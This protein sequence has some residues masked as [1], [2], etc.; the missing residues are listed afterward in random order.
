MANIRKQGIIEFLFHRKRANLVLNIV[1]HNPT[2]PV[3]NL[4]PN[5]IS[6]DGE[7]KP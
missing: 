1:D 2:A 5:I 7:D 6:F 4:V 3:E